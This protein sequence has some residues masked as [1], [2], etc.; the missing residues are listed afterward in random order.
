M[1][2]EQP[3]VQLFNIY[4]QSACVTQPVGIFYIYKRALLC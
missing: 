1:A 4:Q 2:S 3:T